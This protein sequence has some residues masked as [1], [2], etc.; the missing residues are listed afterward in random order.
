VTA[1]DVDEVEDRP[2]SDPTTTRH[3]LVQWWFEPVARS[4]V[5]ALRVLVYLYIP[6]DVLLTTSWVA[7]HADV[8]GALYQP[9]FVGRL[10]PLPTPGETFVNVLMWALLVAAVLAA[11]GRAPRILGATVF[12]LY[13]EWMIVAMSYGKVDHDR[14]AFLVALAVLPTVGRARWRDPTPTEAAGWA[15]R[16]TQVAVVLTYFL[17]AWAKLRFG[18]P[19]W[20]NGA[21]LY[22]AVIRRATEY[23]EWILDYPGLLR[24]S[25][26][27]ILIFELLSP[28]I[29]VARRGLRMALIG[30]LYAFHLMS[31]AFIGI[32]FLPHCVAMAAFLPFER[33]LAVRSTSES[34]EH[35]PQPAVA[36]G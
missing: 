36:S 4:R 24:A 18:G 5:A 23:G 19:E 30:G 8:P 29:F 20:V 9:L 7:N 17:A 21:T 16:C 26:W 3:P 15:I 6:I 10:L 12:V 14:F 28:L 35:V 31:F 34:R 2:L 25:Q 11:T 27:G 33:L 22:R 13:F 32:I 1:V